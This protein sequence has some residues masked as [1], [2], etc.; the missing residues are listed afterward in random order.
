MA[1]STTQTERNYESTL[2]QIEKGYIKQVKFGAGVN[3]FLQSDV[4][5]DAKEETDVIG[6]VNQ[7]ITSLVSTFL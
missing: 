7:T 5:K 2:L 3:A 1:N 4:Y 6:N